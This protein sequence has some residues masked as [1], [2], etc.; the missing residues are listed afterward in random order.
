A[1]STPGGDGGSRGGA[2]G[3]LQAIGDQQVVSGAAPA[4]P[5]RSSA[6]PGGHAVLQ[7][8]GGLVVALIAPGAAFPSAL[9]AFGVTLC[10]TFPS[11]L[12]SLGGL[13]C[14]APSLPPV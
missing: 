8:I 14:P 7:P 3:V 9:A 1:V 6:P 2:H 4:T 5:W 11:A 10:T 12:T 13:R